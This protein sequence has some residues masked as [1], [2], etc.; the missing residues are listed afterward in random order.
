A[1]SEVATL[2][3]MARTAAGAQALAEVKAV[4]GAYPLHGEVRLHGGGTLDDALAPQG[5]A[6][7]AVA[8]RELLAR[9][10]IAPGAT[11]QVG[12]AMLRIADTIAHEPDRLSDGIGFGPRLLMSTD[13]LAATGLIRPGSLVRWRYRVLLPAAAGDDGAVQRLEDEA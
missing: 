6:W 8:D 4:D 3:A 10:D 13:A 7:G 11:I 1:L 9:L 5:E 12:D 2:R